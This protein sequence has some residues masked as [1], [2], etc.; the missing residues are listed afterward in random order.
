MSRLVGYRCRLLA[1][2][3]IAVLLVGCAPAGAPAPAVGQAPAPPAV[4]AG[5]GQTDAP[6]HLVSG[7]DGQPPG[8]PVQWADDGGLIASATAVV[9]SADAEASRLPFLTGSVQA[10]SF[11]SLPGDERNRSA[12]ELWAD[13]Y[14]LQGQGAW[15]GTVTPYTLLYG[16]SDTVKADGGV[17]S[18]GIAYLGEDDQQVVAAFFATIDLTAGTGE[19][20]Y[21]VPG[22]D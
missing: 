15:L 22:N 10:V 19:F 11:L 16:D 12:W 13:A 14:P 4:G 7:K 2:G 6:V 8:Q 1:L 3:V 5:L 21:S 17:H 9:D 18:L 20:R